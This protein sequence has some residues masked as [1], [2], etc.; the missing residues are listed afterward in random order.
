MSYYWPTSL[1]EDANQFTFAKEDPELNPKLT[2]HT[3]SNVFGKGGTVSVD[4]DATFKRDDGTEYTS[5]RSLTK[6][7]IEESRSVV[8]ERDHLQSLVDDWNENAAENWRNLVHESRS[9]VLA[10][11]ERLEDEAAAKL[12]DMRKGIFA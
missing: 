11:Y 3:W 8:Y 1:T 4:Y 7:D 10:H 12:A 6:I 9:K 5:R 2:V